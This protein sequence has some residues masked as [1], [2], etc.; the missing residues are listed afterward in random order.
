MQSLAF[1]NGPNAF[2]VVISVSRFGSMWAE[3]N[4]PDEDCLQAPRTMDLCPDRDFG[5][6]LCGRLFGLLP[7]VKNALFQK[8]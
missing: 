8:A 6:G 4:G 2:S 7:K 3:S 5:L 1:G